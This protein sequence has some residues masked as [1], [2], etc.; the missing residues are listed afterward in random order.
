MDMCVAV[1]PED[2]DGTSS[3]GGLTTGEVV[4]GEGDCCEQYGDQFGGICL[5][6]DFDGDK[7]S[8]EPP[9]CIGCD[10]EPVLC[11]THGCGTPNVKD[12]CLN[13]KGQTVTCSPG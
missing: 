12:C 10:W 6:F 7:V 4:W 5:L 1:E 8:G 2:T 3:S 13:D 9:A 11:M